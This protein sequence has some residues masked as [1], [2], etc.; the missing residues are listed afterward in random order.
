M[1]QPDYA[2]IAEADRVRPAYRLATPLDW[3]ADRVGEVARQPVG[4]ELGVPGPDQGYALKVADELFASRLELSPG[5]T[6]KDALHGCSAVACA[7][8]AGFGRAPVGKDVEIA[9]V[10]FGFLGA[11][12]ADLVE[13]RAALFQAASHDY[14][15]QRRIVDC[16]L[17]E[18]LRLSPDQIRERMSDWRSLVD[19]TAST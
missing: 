4:P 13:W 2:P 16:V 18:T 1:A 14:M 11:A 9:L 10:L 17:P 12:P 7:R 5:I 19:S 3:R 6:T 15:A 8:A